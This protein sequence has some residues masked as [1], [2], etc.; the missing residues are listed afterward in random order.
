[1]TAIFRRE[2]KSYFTNMTGYIFLAALFLSVGIIT[3]AE[4]LISGSAAFEYVL[5]FESIILVLLIPILTMRSMAEDKKTKTD[6]LLYS[7]PVNMSAIVLGKYF[8]MA[9]VWGI[10]C[11][12]VGI[13]P[14]ILSMFGKVFFGTAYSTLL[15]FFLLGAALIAI[16]MFLSSL[17]ESMVIA[18]VL[19]IGISA[20]LYALSLLT[21]L[22]PTDALFSFA[23]LII[24][25]LII[26]AIV[27]FMSG[28][29]LLAL[30]T[31]VIGAVPVCVWY[32]IKSSAFEGLFPKLVEYLAIFDRFYNFAYGVFDVTA[33]VYFLS[34]AIFFV[35][36]S[37]QSFDRRRWA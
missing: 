3:T 34:A 13:I 15:G 31:A 4:C 22:I 30:G 12:T 18:A 14:P 24:L 20:A 5:G 16:C 27:Y 11:L 8:A 17:T 25:A 2:F 23:A 26:A 10:G 35:F 9:A 32:V 1:M 6:K 7:L 29:F 21:A 28:S 36:L 37:V 19:G 33:V